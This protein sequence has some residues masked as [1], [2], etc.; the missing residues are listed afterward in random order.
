MF[1]GLIAYDH[2]LYIAADERSL[3]GYRHS[4]ADHRSVLAP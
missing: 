1:D 3:S 2:F 4:P